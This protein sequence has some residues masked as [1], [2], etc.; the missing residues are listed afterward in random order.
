MAWKYVRYTLLQMSYTL[1]NFMD[2]SVFLVTWKLT[3]KL[4]LGLN[5]LLWS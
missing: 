3:K 5:W 1:Q 2:K 4:E